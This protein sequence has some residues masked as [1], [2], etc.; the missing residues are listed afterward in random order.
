MVKK[1]KDIGY[2]ELPDSKAGQNKNAGAEFLQNFSTDMQ[3]EI[4]KVLETGKYI[5]QEI[6]NESDY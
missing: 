1:A 5:P 2:R 4:K 6:L 3:K